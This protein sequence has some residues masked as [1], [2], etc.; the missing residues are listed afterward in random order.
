[1]SIGTRLREWRKKNK[2]TI[3]E[4]T[5]TLNISTGSLNYYEN[6]Q[7]EIGS[8]TLIKLKEIYNADI[9]YILTGMSNN[10]SQEENELLGLF[11]SIPAEKQ[12]RFL[13]RVD[14]IMKDF[15]AEQ[16]PDQEDGRPDFKLSDSKIG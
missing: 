2:I 4:L 3:K 9:F 14:E 1:M 8:N 5:E 11:R 10:L 13:G 6:D 15:P 12:Q 7:R 16:A